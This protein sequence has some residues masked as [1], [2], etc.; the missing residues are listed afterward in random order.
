MKLFHIHLWRVMNTSLLLC[1]IYVCFKISMALLEKSV[2]GSNNLHLYVIFKFVVGEKI[3]AHLYRIL[4]S[5]SGHWFLCT[6]L[7]CGPHHRNSMPSSRNY[8]YFT[9]ARMIVTEH[10]R[11]FSTSPLSPHLETCEDG[12]VDEA[13]ACI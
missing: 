13:R 10:D 7:R 6:A 2:T 5:H 12:A 1:I 9:M 4:S 8:T 11:P 3:K